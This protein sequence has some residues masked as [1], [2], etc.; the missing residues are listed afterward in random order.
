MMGLDRQ[1]YTMH[2]V[3]VLYLASSE[4]KERLHRT[5]IHIFYEDSVCDVLKV[6]M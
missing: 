3:D 5:G 1:E 2:F 6:H 4:T